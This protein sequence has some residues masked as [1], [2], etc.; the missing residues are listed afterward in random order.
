M[1]RTLFV[2]GGV[3]EHWGYISA[4]FTTGIMFDLRLPKAY[5]GN[6]EVAVDRIDFGGLRLCQLELAGQASRIAGIS[7]TIIEKTMEPA[8]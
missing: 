2:C 7:F 1:F 8:G 4:S 5:E 6:R 3:E